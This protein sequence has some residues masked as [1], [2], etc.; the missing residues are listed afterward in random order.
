[1]VLVDDADEVL[2]QALTP[3]G[4]DTRAA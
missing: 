1:M 2:R 3:T 4:A